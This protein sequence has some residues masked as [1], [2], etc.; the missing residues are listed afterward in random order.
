[1]IGVTGRT[2]QCGFVQS[3]REKVRL[4]EEISMKEKVLR[5]T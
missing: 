3:R 2:A 4:Q 1:M 5:E